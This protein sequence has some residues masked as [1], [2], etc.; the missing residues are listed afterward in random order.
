VEKPSAFKVQARLLGLSGLLPLELTRSGAGTDTYLRGVWDLWWRDRDG[1]SDA[2][3]PR[4]L[5]RLHGLRPANHP[6]RRLAL[7]AA[8]AVTTGLG[9]RVERW[10]AKELANKELVGALFQALKVDAD[11]FWS[12]HWTLNS[13]RFQKEQ[14]LL[15]AT[16]VTDLAINVVLP[17]LWI[18]AIE[19]E[20]RSMQ[21]RLEQRYF[22]WPAAEDNSVLRLARQRLLGGASHRELRNAATQQ[23][24]I[25]IIRDF[26]DHSN[27]ICDQCRLPELVNDFA[28]RIQT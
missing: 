11:D 20:N 28:L 18:R 13:P 16:R 2:V 24:L 22:D 25:Q 9:A 7:A 23:G 8:W 3:L 15:G 6:Q 5:W 12:W 14:P 21:S 10:C 4:M 26:C 27:S 19:G 17:W 1:F